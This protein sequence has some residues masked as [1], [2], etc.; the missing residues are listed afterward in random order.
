MVLCQAVSDKLHNM[1]EKYP[2]TQPSKYA[3]TIQKW[4]STKA[5]QDYAVNLFVY[6][7]GLGALTTYLLTSSHI[8]QIISAGAPTY[9]NLQ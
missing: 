6:L 3:K 7:E 4:E 9:S 8:W 2:I 1:I 5:Y